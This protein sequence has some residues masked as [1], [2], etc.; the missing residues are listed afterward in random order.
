MGQLVLSLS[1]LPFSITC[2]LY[3]RKKCAHIELYIIEQRIINN[4]Y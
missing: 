2:L 1:K 3:H 4:E